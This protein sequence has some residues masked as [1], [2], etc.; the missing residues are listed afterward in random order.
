[1]SAFTSS[2]V[3]RPE[4]MTHA[5]KLLWNCTLAAAVLIACGVLGGFLYEQAPVAH[6]MAAPAIDDATTP[7]FA[8]WPTAYGVPD[9]SRVV[10]PA[11]T[12]DDA[13][14]TF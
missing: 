8:T 4:G 11:A 14:P 1:M 7:G 10:F 13:P 2:E 6:A 3:W 12:D 9:A 5:R